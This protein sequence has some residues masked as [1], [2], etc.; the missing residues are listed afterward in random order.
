MTTTIKLI[1]S[2]EKKSIRVTVNGENACNE[3]VY[4]DD[5]TLQKNNYMSEAREFAFTQCCAVSLDGN[6]VTVSE[7]HF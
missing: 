2:K 4:E 1:H 5:N 3:W 6:T 7:N